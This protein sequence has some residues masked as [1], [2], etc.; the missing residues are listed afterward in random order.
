VI[1]SV[2]LFFVLSSFFSFANWS[3]L[4]YGSLIGWAVLSFLFRRIPAVMLTYACGGLRN[5]ASWREALFFGWFAPAGAASS[6][7]AIVVAEHLEKYAR[8]E[9]AAVPPVD[10]SGAASATAGERRAHAAFHLALWFILASVVMHGLL[11]PS[12]ALL[13]RRWQKPVYR[14]EE[15][16]KEKQEEEEKKKE[17]QP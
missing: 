13:L 6:Y 9:A 17:E 10:G 8:E 7:Y 11:G 2:A 16:Q 15:T 1:G 14:E 3:L 4:G 12:A 5:L